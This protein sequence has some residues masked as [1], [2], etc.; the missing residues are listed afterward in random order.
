VLHVPVVLKTLLHNDCSLAGVVILHM[1]PEGHSRTFT[2][3]DKGIH[4]TEA[5]EFTVGLIRPIVLPGYALPRHVIAMR[6]PVLHAM[7]FG[8]LG[9]FNRKYNLLGVNVLTTF[10]AV[11]FGQHLQIMTAEVR[12]A[13]GFSLRR[14]VNALRDTVFV[15]LYA[16]EQPSLHSLFR[17]A[18]TATSD[19]VAK[20]FRGQFL[21][22]ETVV[23]VNLARTV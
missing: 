12:L 6:R 18:A 7:F 10:V 3:G 19:T 23:Y 15:L 20:L 1:R 14:L 5:E 2:F 16:N 17:R 13:K 22:L 8:V 9:L 11:A 4:H 21:L